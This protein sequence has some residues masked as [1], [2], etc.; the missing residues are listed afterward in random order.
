ML[1]ERLFSW[2]IISV[3][4]K[5]LRTPASTIQ[6]LASKLPGASTFFLTY[7]GLLHSIVGAILSYRLLQ[8][9]KAWREPEWR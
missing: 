5:I 8:S 9:A 2:L 7:M 4:D 1:C 6:S 3:V